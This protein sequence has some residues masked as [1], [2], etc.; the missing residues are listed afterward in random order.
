MS[1]NPGRVTLGVHRTSIYIIP[2]S[3]TPIALNIFY[4]EEMDWARQ[5]TQQCPLQ[6]SM[7]KSQNSSPNHTYIHTFTTQS[8]TGYLKTL[9]LSRSN[10]KAH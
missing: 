1:S 7:Y 9:K 2:D 5:T 6:K 4:S 10:S 3:K 8:R